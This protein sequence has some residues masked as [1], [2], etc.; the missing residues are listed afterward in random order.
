[1]TV[2][3]WKQSKFNGY[4]LGKELYKDRLGTLFEAEHEESAF[5]AWCK[6]FHTPHTRISSLQNK[7]IQRT[8]EIIGLQH[9][10]LVAIYTLGLL[11]EH[12]ILF[13]LLERLAGLSLEDALQ[14]QEHLP[15]QPLLPFFQCLDALHYMHES[16]IV[17]SDLR[18]RTLYL[19]PNAQTHKHQAYLL[20]FGQSWWWDDRLQHAG[21]CAPE[22]QIYLAPEQ[23]R[24]HAPLDHRI[25]L[26]AAALLLLEMI[27][28]KHLYSNAAALPPVEE[29]DRFLEKVFQELKTAKKDTPDLEAFFLRA[30]A[31]EPS[32]RF[33]S[34]R[35][36]KQH[37]EVIFGISSAHLEP[38]EIEKTSRHIYINTY[39][40]EQD[41]LEQTIIDDTT[42]VKDSSDPN[43]ITAQHRPPSN[44]W[45]E[46]TIQAHAREKSIQRQ[47]FFSSHMAKL[48]LE[49][50]RKRNTKMIWMA[51]AV[52][53]GF[54]LTIMGALFFFMEPN[55]PTKAILHLHTTPSGAYIWK[56]RWKHLHPTPTT[57]YADTNKKVRIHIH[58]PGYV[59]F[60]FVWN[61]QQQNTSRTIKLQKQP[62]LSTRR[63]E[64]SSP[65]K[66][67]NNT[68][69]RR[70]PPST[71]EPK[72]SPNP[73]PKVRT[74]NVPPPRQNFLKVALF[75]T[76]SPT[77]AR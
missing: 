57:L 21:G 51:F 53:F 16:S 25:D 31:E 62:P 42:P 6:V 64:P 66:A 3:Q 55:T 20:F 39:T 15:Q 48:E 27:L 14:Y 5:P 32:Q 28:Q 73:N 74:V 54:A 2:P 17:H 4:S 40:E 75:V 8:Q 60:F 9:S 37:L 29:H 7:L 10:H 35:I 45:E 58:K 77:H 43:A 33:D 38:E 61:T 34:A 71:T 36:M 13:V 12:Q 30:L 70:E 76:T 22:S 63:T 46:N 67:K 1:M 68:P 50:A 52:A 49:N 56:D 44:A 24:E 59:P 41:P 23:R 19:T 18:P 47:A 11:P 72:R 65:I 69:K 26:Y